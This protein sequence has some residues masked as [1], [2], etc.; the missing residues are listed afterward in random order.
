MSPDAASDRRRFTSMQ[1]LFWLRNAALAIQITAVAVAHFSLEV[2]L[3]IA[4]LIVILAALALFNVMTGVRLARG[5][6]ETE[7]GILVEILVDVA[8]LTA[9]LYFTGGSTNPFTV[10]YLLPLTLAALMLPRQKLWIVAALSAACYSVLLKFHVPLTSVVDSHDVMMRLHVFGMWMTFLLSATLITYFVSQIRDRDVQLSKT[11]ENTLRNQRV[12]AI[13]TMAAGA[14]HELGTPL[15]TIGVLAKELQDQ[16]S[17]H[18]ALVD[19][20]AVLRRQVEACKLTITNLLANA[21]QSR[22]D[23]ASARPVTEF[24]QDVL[25]KWQLM[26]PIVRTQS[27]VSG[28]APAPTIV[29]DE[30]LGQA[31]MN[32]LNNAADASPEQVEIETRWTDASAVVEVLDRGPGFPAEAMQSAGGAFF[33]TKEP[34]SGRGLGLFLARAAVERVGGELVLNAREGGGSIARLVLPIAGEAG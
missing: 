8:A 15:T 7:T 11:R 9:L 5:A 30:T 28:P 34:G 3:P 21:Q 33:S 20:L 10:F 2:E 12:L 13:G 26:R 14:A 19:D 1:Q 31:L 32:L 23:A 25:H 29:T 27:R 18:K 6:I 24:V 4:P 17:D 22:F 16:Y